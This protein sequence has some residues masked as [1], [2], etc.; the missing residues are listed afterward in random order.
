MLNSDLFVARR[1]KI[2]KAQKQT[3][4]Y[5]ENENHLYFIVDMNLFNN[6][7]HPTAFPRSLPFAMHRLL[8]DDQSLF[9]FLPYTSIVKELSPWVPFEWATRCDGPIFHR[10]TTDVCFLEITHT[11][12][13]CPCLRSIPPPIFRSYSVISDKV[14]CAFRKTRLSLTSTN[15]SFKYLHSSPTHIEYYMKQFSARIKVVC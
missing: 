10:H 3:S 1:I 9:I 14:L 12:V 13:V 4:R 11:I 6:F 2:S 8:A 7:G 15:L 5:Y